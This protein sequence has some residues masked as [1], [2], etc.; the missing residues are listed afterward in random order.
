[1][2]D[3]TGAIRRASEIWKSSPLVLYFYPADFTPGC[4]KEA[5][6]FAEVD[7]LIR[8][9][10]A[11]LVGVSVDPVESHA[12]FAE[13]CGAAFPLLADTTAAVARAYGAAFE[14]NRDGRSRT[15][16]RRV[17]YLIDAKGTIARSW[18]VSDPLIHP[19]EVVR[20]L[21]LGVMKGE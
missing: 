13:H 14:L 19:E 15:V 17:T 2:K 11:N 6:A 9:R 3:Q 20:A 7:S 16:A 12:R 10:G 5:H 8:A 18:V 21:P 4:T 1:M